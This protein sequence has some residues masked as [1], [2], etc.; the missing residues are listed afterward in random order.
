MKTVTLEVAAARDVK[1]RTLETFK[2]NRQVPITLSRP[3]Y[4]RILTAKQ[5]ES[6]SPWPSKDH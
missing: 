1:R 5:W 2:G 4:C 3:N 6:L